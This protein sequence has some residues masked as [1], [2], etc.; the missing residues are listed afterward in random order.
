MGEEGAV[1]WWQNAVVYQLYVRSF[2]DADSNGIG[3]LAGIESRLGY[4]RDLG[5]NALWLNPCYP[6]PQ[7]DHG[8]DVADYFDVEPDY[9]D[10]A[11][12]DRLVRAANNNNIRV[13][14]D[15]VPNHCSTANRWFQSAL[16]SFPGSPER[17]WFYF[18]EGK[19]PNGDE[20]PNNWVSWFGG[21]AWTRFTELDGKIGQWYLHLFTPAQP[22]LNWNHE[23]VRQAFDDILRFWFDRGVDGFRIDAPCVAGKAP[24]LPDA[25]PVPPGT[26]ATDAAGRNPHIQHRPE[27]HEMFARWR[28]VTDEYVMTHPGRELF[29][30]GETYAPT[31]DIVTSYVGPTE[32]QST[33]YFDLLLANWQA[34][35]WRQGVADIA[36]TYRDGLRLAV[37]LNNHDSQRTVTRYGHRDSHLGSS[38]TF[39]NLVNSNEPVDVVV[40]ARRARAAAPS[41][42]ARRGARPDA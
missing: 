15:I 42:R 39:N 27:V 16:H 28:R 21:S 10:L 4:L 3:D 30:V 9:G 13:L 6:S 12:F 36:K 34:F 24:G 1:P 18:R 32:L 23:P 11:S 8:Y 41:D 35:R 31:L 20:P 37:T 19:G 40:G 22:D 17:S 29:F 25:P 38:F 5:V 14:M 2:A 33:F 7:V 26:P